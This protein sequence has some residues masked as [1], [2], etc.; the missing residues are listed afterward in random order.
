MASSASR[1]RKRPAAQA[2]SVTS[3]QGSGRDASLVDSGGSRCSIHHVDTGSRASAADGSDRD[4]SLARSGVSRGSMGDGCKM[5]TINRPDP[6]K[7]KPLIAA[8]L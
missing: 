7:G 2:G 8:D 3:V 6:S 1:I 4:V 5:S